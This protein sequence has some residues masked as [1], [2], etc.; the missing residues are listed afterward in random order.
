[1]GYHSE[2]PH[3]KTFL[4]DNDYDCFS[5]YEDG[6]FEVTSEQYNDFYRGKNISI[7]FQRE[8]NVLYMLKKKGYYCF[9]HQSRNGSLTILNGGAMKKLEIPDIQY[10]Y[11]NMDAMI[12]TIKTPLDKFTSFQNELQI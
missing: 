4:I 10:Y 1:M 5:D 3:L 2:D 11:D 9:I 6:I 7:T 12:S 8:V